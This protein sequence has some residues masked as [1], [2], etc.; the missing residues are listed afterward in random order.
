MKKV[1]LFCLI[2]MWVSACDQ[3]NPSS[4]PPPI[5]RE[6]E[7]RL[8]EDLRR[9]R[10]RRDQERRQLEAERRK[11][12]E[13]ARRLEDRY[14]QA[15]METAATEEDLGGALL[16][17]AATGL[18]LVVVIFLLARERRLRMLVTRLLDILWR[19]LNS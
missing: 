12:A 2:V 13:Q 1:V 17:W 4:S 14:R 16:A 11:H 8:A 6:R 15:R 3:P 10:A 18:A 7:N 9:E 5:H 19:R